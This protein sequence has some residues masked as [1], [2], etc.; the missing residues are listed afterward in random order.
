VVSAKLRGITSDLLPFPPGV[1]PAY[2]QLATDCWAAQPEQRPTAAEV[3]AQLGQL[4]QQLLGRQLP[5]SPD[6]EAPPAA[7][8]SAAG[9]GAAAL[10]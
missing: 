2:V 5:P 7:P 3:D 6:G 9:T 1:P 8:A 4:A 10:N